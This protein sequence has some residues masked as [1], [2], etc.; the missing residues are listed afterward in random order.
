MSFN[1]TSDYINCGTN[2]SLDFGAGSFTVSV[3]IKPTSL[4]SRDGI[5][6]RRGGAGGYWQLTGLDTNNVQF[7]VDDG[8]TTP[9][10]IHTYIQLN[11]WTHI[12]GIINRDTN[13]IQIYE[14]GVF[15]IQSD[16]ESPEEVWRT[17]PKASQ[18]YIVDKNIKVAYLDGF[19]IAREETTHPDLQFRMQGIA[20]QGAFFESS[21]IAENAGK[22]K[23]DILQ[24]IHDTIKA[25][26]GSK[27]EQVVEDN[28]R[29]VKRGFTET[30]HLIVAEMQ[31]GDVAPWAVK[32]EQTAPL[33]LLQKPA[34]DDPLSDIHRF[35]EQTGTNYINGRANDNLADPF[36]ALSIIPAASGIYR[37]MTQ[38][39]FEHPEW[40]PENCTACGD[41]YTVC[42]DSAIP[43]LI[44]SVN[45]V[46]E[47]NI[48]RI[49]KTGKTVKHLRRAIRN[50]EKK[51]HAL[52]ADKSEGTV[53][54]PIFNKS[55]GETI[56]EYP[57]EQQA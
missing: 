22:S 32:K 27:G 15:I 46:F 1:G 18:Q 57:E 54:D 29:T 2:S 47:T 26:F 45:E 25:K 17:F 38:V 23:D 41:C 42:P 20:F 33:M 19:K 14:N 12:V 52:T 43:G 9:K 55:I 50:V 35:F 31:V 16:L 24:A 44:N 8:A 21:P 7:Y 40:I 37:D 36:M 48:T 10:Y 51:Y 13:Y 39:R 6:T 53:L 5:V 28:F 11:Q 3:W 56:K 30:K 34:N 49:E 4:V